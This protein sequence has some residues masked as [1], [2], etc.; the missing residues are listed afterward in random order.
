VKETVLDGL[1]HGFEVFHLDDA[2][3]GVNVNPSDSQRALQE[4]VAKGAQRI[5]F[6]DITVKHK[7]TVARTPK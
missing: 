2:S 3:K 1:K 4:M 7:V 5:R 6:Q